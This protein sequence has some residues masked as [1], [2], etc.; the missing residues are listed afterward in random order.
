MLPAPQYDA[1]LES[2]VEYLHSL[3][4]DGQWG[5]DYHT[6]LNVFSEDDREQAR[7]DLERAHDRIKRQPP[8]RASVLPKWLGDRFTLVNRL[9]RGGM[10]DVF[11]VCDTNSG[12]NVALKVLH[13]GQHFGRFRQEA[14]L[15]EEIDSSRIVKVHELIESTHADAQGAAIVMDY[16]QGNDLGKMIR[17]REQEFEFTE[18]IKWMT[19]I[20]QAMID[21]S[22]ENITHRDIKPS[23]I[24][25]REA[26]NVALLADFGLATDRTSDGDITGSRA[27]MTAAGAILGTASYMSPEQVRDSKAADVRNDIYG[28]GATFYHVCTGT[29][30]HVGEDW[31]ETLYKVRHE[32]MTSPVMHNPKIPLNLVRILETALAKKARDRFQTFEEL[33]SQLDIILAASDSV[34]AP[35]IPASDYP[36]DHHE[37][38]PLLSAKLD[39]SGELEVELA[40][41]EIPRGQHYQVERRVLSE[42]PMTPKSERDPKIPIAGRRFANGKELQIVVGDIVEQGQGCEVIVSSDDGLLRMNAGVSNR[43]KQVAGSVVQ[44]EAQRFTPVQAGR[45]IATS[46]GKLPQRMIF[47]GITLALPVSQMKGNYIP[48]TDLIRN[49]LDSCCYHIESS[50]IK[51]IIF[52]LLGTGIAG[53]EA[54][55]CLETMIEYLVRELEEGIT[56]LQEARIVVLPDVFDELGPV[57]E[58]LL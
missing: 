32:P 4:I 57:I 47:H 22:R 26:D 1:Q 27:D 16:V 51:S 24:M 35:T 19:G 15:L 48:T 7:Q 37:Q 56:P 41:D 12:D 5:G 8:P 2:A 30:P 55:R 49:I 34:A 9:G 21:V 58:R 46:A 13:D 18:V 3:I 50:Q 17:R 31:L 23:N 52:P 40:D 43:I 29:A 45:A 33:K 28:F 20:A 11:L 14:L 6:L 38:L 44:E 25:I 54:E 53:M 39:A 36:E 42:A 10:A